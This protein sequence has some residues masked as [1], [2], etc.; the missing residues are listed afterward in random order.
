MCFFTKNLRR[1]ITEKATL[2]TRM[3][4]CRHTRLKKLLDRLRILSTKVYFF[5]LFHCWCAITSSSMLVTF[6]ARFLIGLKCPS[7]ATY[8]GWFSFS[9]SS[10]NLNGLPSYLPY[11]FF[12]SSGALVLGFF[13]LSAANMQYKVYSIFLTAIVL[14][15]KEKL[16]LDRLYPCIL[17]WKNCLSYLNA[18]LILPIY[19]MWKLLVCVLLVVSYENISSGFTMTAM[20]S[21]SGV[22]NSRLIP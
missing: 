2:P 12:W 6:F 10:A 7:V 14:V 9:I 22:V 16:S 20:V 11:W 18:K 15:R 3:R 19:I 4:I 5:S 8:V 13:F 21:L 17:V 1:F